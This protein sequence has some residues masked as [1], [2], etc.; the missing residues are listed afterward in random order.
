MV[1]YRCR[2]QSPMVWR[3]A[4]SAMRLFKAFSGRN[5]EI[6]WL[7]YAL[8]IVLVLYFVFVRSRM[9]WRNVDQAS[10]GSG[11][12][13]SEGALAERAAR[14]WKSGIRNVFHR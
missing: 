7:T 3:W 11:P 4:S 8:A 10:S 9:G 13:E 14:S 6:S 2:I 1:S 12:S 5:R